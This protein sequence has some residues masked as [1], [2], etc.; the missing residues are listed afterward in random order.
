M[1]E[2]DV[3]GR[4]WTQTYVFTGYVR[5][6]ETPTLYSRLERRIYLESCQSGPEAGRQRTTHL[7]GHGDNRGG[8]YVGLPAL[9]ARRCVL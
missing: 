7:G 5:W 3:D 6:A 4:E 9:G 2:D 1:D 8:A